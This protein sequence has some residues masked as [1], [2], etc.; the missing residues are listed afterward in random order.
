MLELIV[1]ADRGWGIGKDGK[2]LFHIEQD[3]EFF[4]SKTVGK[5]VIVG[6]KTLDSFPDKEPL[7]DRV[8]IVLTRDSEFNREG[9]TVCRT[10]N[11]VLE[12][13]KKYPEAFV[14]GGGEIY[15]LLLPYC[16]RAYVT[17]VDATL[18]SDTCMV[19]LDR[20]KDWKMVSE[21]K[22]FTHG[23]FTYR[24]AVYERIER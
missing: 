7:K 1:C 11:E 10:V 23:E 12:E 18:P 9:V 6:R 13:A 24:F 16:S 22:D 20:E 15:S 14:I 19:N 3:M 8:N 2:L 4:K 21:T 17:K 5:A